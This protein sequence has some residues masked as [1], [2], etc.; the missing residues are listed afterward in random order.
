MAFSQETRQFAARVADRARD[1]WM[2]A[3]AVGFDFLSLITFIL[4]FLRDCRE[5]DTE[6]GREKMIKTAYNKIM[7]YGCDN[8]IEA[9][10]TK[11]QAERY[12]KKVAKKLKL[13]SKQQQDQHFANAVVAA[14]T[15]KDSAVKGMTSAYDND[16]MDDEDE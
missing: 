2:G 3:K 4:G 15:E 9:C 14:W 16:E 7:L 11:K 6:E 10:M 1:M 8:C 13:K 5:P 12:R